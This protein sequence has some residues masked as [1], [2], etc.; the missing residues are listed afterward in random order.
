MVRFHQEI[1]TYKREFVR[2]DCPPGKFDQTLVNECEKTAELCFRTMLETQL[3]RT[4]RKPDLEQPQL[5]RDYLT[6]YTRVDES[7]LCPQL[8]AEAQVQRDRP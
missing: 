7:Q 3:C 6:R 4:F 8:W 2:Y 5:V 1:A